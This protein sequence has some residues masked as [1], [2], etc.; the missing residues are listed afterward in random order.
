MS[1]DVP[2][3]VA[4]FAHAL[5]ACYPKAVV[6][7][8]SHR[9]PHKPNHQLRRLAALFHR[10]APVLLCTALL[11]QIQ[12]ADSFLGCVQQELENSRLAILCARDRERIPRSSGPA[13][14]TD[15]TPSELRSSLSRRGIPVLFVGHTHA[16]EDDTSRSIIVAILA[17]QG[18]P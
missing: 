12:D 7:V 11:D 14:G 18:M 8:V 10:N 9:R 4:A 6:R 5:T 1:H 13:E 17:G 2:S 15:W 3:Q 16:T